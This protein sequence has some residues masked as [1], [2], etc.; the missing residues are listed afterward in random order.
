MEELLKQLNASESAWRK[1]T[2]SPLDFLEKTGL[3]LNPETRNLL[4]K[5][6][7]RLFKEVEYVPGWPI[8]RLPKGVRQNTFE[9]LMV[10]EQIFGKES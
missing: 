10:H 1:F 4:L 7:A 5:D 8:S 2:Q 3:S 6:F 9:I